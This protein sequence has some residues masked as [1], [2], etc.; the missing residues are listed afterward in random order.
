MMKM[1]KLNIGILFLAALCVQLTLQVGA[2]TGTITYIANQGEKGFKDAFKGV[3]NAFGLSKSAHILPNRC[4]FFNDSKASVWVSQTVNG[5][6]TTP[7]EVKAGMQHNITGSFTV[8]TRDPKK[9]YIQMVGGKPHTFYVPEIVGCPGNN[10][11]F[12]SIQ[13]FADTLPQGPTPVI[14]ESINTPQTR[15]GGRVTVSVPPF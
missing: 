1:A 8:E 2:A 10:L 7:V 9:F 4:H 6:A 12:S 11:K 13:Q 15:L 5:K 14:R 3:S